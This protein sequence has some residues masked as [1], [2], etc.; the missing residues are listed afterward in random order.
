M[1]PVLETERLILRPLKIE[2]FEDYY[3]YANDPET[4][5]LGLWQ[6]YLSR[7]D[8]RAD[9]EGLIREYQ[10][11]RFFWWALEEK[12][13]H[14][15]IGRC[16]LGAYSRFHSRAEVSYAL[17][18]LYWRKG[19]ISEAI[20]QVIQYGFEVLNLNRISAVCLP[21]NKGSQRVLEKAGMILEGVMRQ[22]TFV[23][24]KFDDLN[25]YSLLREEWIHP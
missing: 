22:H 2:D 7:E 4:A 1:I 15:L 10:T 17:N 8:A 3:E 13:D 24:G 5:Y 14:K 6:P 11:E 12:T 20:K 19:Y 23:H 21:E 25:L 9:L 16:E 18:R